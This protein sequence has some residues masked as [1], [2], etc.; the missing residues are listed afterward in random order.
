MNQHTK[1]LAE[2]ATDTQR[3][4]LCRHIHT[5]GHRC[6]AAALTGA[7]LCFYHTRARVQQPASTR[8]GTFSMPPTGDRAAIQLALSDLAARIAGGDIDLRRAGYL[9]KV[10]REASLNLSRRTLPTAADPA[11]A[12]PQVEDLTHHPHLGDLAPIAE[13]H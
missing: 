3:R 5:L 2:P 1:P 8:A 6:R 7:E 12:P 4:Y 13:Y 10:L 9:L 11:T